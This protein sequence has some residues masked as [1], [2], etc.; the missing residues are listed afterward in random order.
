V[1][2]SADRI[3]V[4]DS[5]VYVE[6]HGKTLFGG[7]VFPEEMPESEEE[8]KG[9]R[10]LAVG[11]GDPAGVAPKESAPSRDEGDEEEEGEEPEEG[12]E[13]GVTLNPCYEIFRVM[14][15]NGIVTNALPYGLFSHRCPTTVIPTMVT[16]VADMHEDDRRELV[17]LVGNAEQTRLQ[18]RAAR[19]KLVL[20]GAGAL[21]RG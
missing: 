14:N 8:P 15:E 11:T 6:C 7:E 12:F 10:A 18:S 3:T 16:R 17:R 1:S 13:P 5:W 4:D 19:A 2:S 21:A 9:T 20:A